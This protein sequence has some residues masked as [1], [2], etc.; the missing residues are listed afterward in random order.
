MIACTHTQARYLLP[1][2][3]PAF[4]KQFPKVHLSLAEGSPAQLA[5]TRARRRALRMARSYRAGSALRTRE[6]SHARRCSFAE[7]NRQRS[8][9]RRRACAKY[10]HDR[11]KTH[12]LPALR[13][14]P[15]ARPGRPV[16]GLQ[17]RQ[18]GRRRGLPAEHRRGHAGGGAAEPAG[19]H[20]VAVLARAL[21]GRSGACLAAAI[22]GGRAGVAAPSAYFNGMQMRVC[23]CA[24]GVVRVENM[25]MAYWSKRY[26]GARRLDNGLV[27][28]AR[29]AN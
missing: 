27:A 4:R 6:Y 14:L 9:R 19:D 8:P 22:P 18:R 20:R 7:R 10:P 3:I 1:R 12:R 21:P 28:S 17:R 11:A 26:N 13:R 5:G 24:G 16:A 15:A 23:N 2:V 29:A 25:T